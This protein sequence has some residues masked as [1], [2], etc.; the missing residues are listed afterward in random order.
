MT[1]EERLQAILQPSVDTHARYYTDFE[2]LK[3]VTEAIRAE[4]RRIV[5]TQGVYDLLHIGHAQYLAKA[6]EE[7]DVLIVGVDS[8]AL[9][10]QRKGDGR[11][12]VPEG[13][14]TNMI[15]HLRDVDMVVLRDVDKELEALIQTIKPDVYIAST[16]T[17]DFTVSPELA[18]HC[19]EVRT[20]P[21]QATTSTSARVQQV[22]MLGADELAAELAKQMPQVVH[23][24]LDQ[25]KNKK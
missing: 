15:L 22:S 12:V 1:L 2:E 17:K 4:G 7:G 21:P 13:E 10:R 6:K 19:G 24:M 3:D 5:L 9:T 14:R 8:D 25:I 23:A 20:L 18:E 11:P 16:S